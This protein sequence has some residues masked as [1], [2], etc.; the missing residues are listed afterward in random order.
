M[1]LPFQW[2]LDSL[3]Y[4]TA[5]LLSQNNTK[6]GT[7]KGTTLS[8]NKNF[9]IQTATFATLEETTCSTSIVKSA[10]RDYFTLLQLTAL[11]PKVHIKP[12]VDL[13]EFLLD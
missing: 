6:D 7:T 5:S 1:C 3:D 10:I 13:R 12:K 9:W 8:P 11:R 2:F 4:A